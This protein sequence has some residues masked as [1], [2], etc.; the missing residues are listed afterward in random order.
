MDYQ[1]GVADTI[2]C[3]TV[4]TT[5]LTVADTLLNPA[6]ATTNVTDHCDDISVSEILRTNSFLNL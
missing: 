3:S 5:K 6:G 1:F 2:P 4:T